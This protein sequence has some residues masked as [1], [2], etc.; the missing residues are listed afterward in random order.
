VQ[1]AQLVPAT[2][3]EAQEREVVG[4]GVEG[5][6]YVCACVWW[7]VV[8]VLLERFWGLEEM[9]VILGGGKRLD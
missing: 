9:E 6:G 7:W 1:T 2:A 8:W 3:V 4:G 5:H